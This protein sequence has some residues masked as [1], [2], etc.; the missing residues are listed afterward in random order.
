MLITNADI[1]KL[2]RNLPCAE[3]ARLFYERLVAE[4]PRAARGLVSDAALLSDVLALAA[5]SP[6]LATTL[7][8]NPDYIQWLA[9]ERK[10]L[11]LKTREEL[12]ESLGRFS[13]T[14][15][16][17]DPHVLLSRFR[18]RELLRIYLRDIRQLSTVAETTEEL[19]NLA[20]SAL[21]YALNLARQQLDNRYGAPLCVDDKG[22]I[23]TASFSVIALGKLG[24]RELNYS[25]DI[26]LFS[27]F[28]DEGSTSGKGERGVI[29]NREY[30]VKLAQ[31]VSRIIGQTGGEGAAYRVDLRLRPH[32]R[33]GAL[34]SSLDEAVRYYNETAQAWEL[35]AL[36]RARSSAG[37]SALF[38]RFSE[39]VR[40]RVFRQDVTVAEALGDVRL[41]KQKIDREHAQ[42]SHG[43]N[44]KLGRG[45][46]REI[47]FI[48]Q[49]L[50][51]AYGG[52]D[53]WLRAQH[54]LIALSRLAER[55][56]I[57]K[58]ELAELTEAYAF[59]RTLEHRLQME[60]GLQ[61]HTVPADD[62]KRAIVARRMNFGG[63]SALTDF[64][65][66]L[67][68]H[69][70]KVRAA[71]ERVFGSEAS[72]KSAP[73]PPCI[74]QVKPVQP[75]DAEALAASAA[76]RV[77]APRL[78][79]F[80]NETERAAIE[81]AEKI[82]REA[83][84]HALNQHRALMMAARV[85]ASLEKFSGE[86]E[87][88]EEALRELVRICGA[89]EFFGD[90]LACH[91]ELV[92]LA[93][94]ADASARSRPFHTL[95]L[96]SIEQSEEFRSR[97]SALRRIWAKLL[98][99]I[100]ALDS[101]GNI[102]MTEANAMQT[103]LAEA[104][105][106]AGLRIARD[107][108]SR[109]FDGLDAEP[110]MAVLGLGR[111]GG[112]GM[113]YGSDLDVVLIYDDALPSPLKH[114]THSEAYGR[115]AELLVTA[116]SSMTR[117]RYLY[118]VDLRLRPDGK[119]GATAS[120]ARAF[121]DYLENR[122]VEWE[123]LAYVKLRAAAGDLGLA[124]KIEEEARRVV[125]SVARRGNLENLRTETL[126]VRERLEKERTHKKARNI[127]IKFGAGGMLD[128]YFVTRYLQLR[129]CVPDS[130]QD[131]STLA[132]LERLLSSGSLAR[133]DFRTMS[134][135]Y[136]LLRKVDHALRLVVGRSTRLPSHG[137]PALS[138]IARA[139]G[140]TSTNTLNEELTAR[141]KEIRAA[142][143]RG[144]RAEG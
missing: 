100:G 46:I 98:F 81:K 107:E 12:A 58:R 113:D 72:E 118:R 85:A 41:A 71:F 4:E 91:P 22:R 59:L 125:H 18:R 122:S 88:T 128:V 68:A 19:S 31:A 64:D 117:D 43:F 66:A 45:G 23:T 20:D 102:S 70:S 36:I 89:S 101:A 138:D 114:L 42:S 38:A 26:D 21:Q 5:W 2:V 69:T 52:S 79:D 75:L 104:S 32:G 86:T 77:F 99:E 110:R 17:L 44:V 87:V 126:R 54:T 14:N 35:Q 124:R 1:L 141:M 6:L 53:E 37:D 10:L 25:S 48:A 27:L 90:M 112:R 123:W 130:S 49:A 16:Q 3:S 136:A 30:F 62:E 76:A 116:L 93:A 83:A 95:L 135:G 133:E 144:M 97:L 60:H 111:L 11:R 134:E 78:K 29:T 84:A 33:D 34:A 92:A 120:S 82:L 15:S 132:T 103:E 109:K 73:A 57:M 140:Y 40:H 142:Y 56:L 13:L 7:L 115:L 8:Q 47:E 143:E 51:L 121:L 137:H 61:T 106:D 39:R 24:S 9:R 96:E 74:H 67:R 108:L 127:D 80:K 119:N 65:A 131:R 28:S 50:E 129:D 139:A 55:Q 63:A 105:I 94:S